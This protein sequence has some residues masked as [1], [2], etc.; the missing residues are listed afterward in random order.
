MADDQTALDDAELESA[1]AR[2]DPR[3]AHHDHVQSLIDPLERQGG[4][5]ALV[6]GTLRAVVG[7]MFHWTPPEA[8]EAKPAMTPEEALADA[9]ATGAAER[10]AANQTGGEPPE[11]ET[12]AADP[13]EA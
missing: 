6:A 5:A 12:Q 7:G 2:T 4:L 10:E 1:A 8:G 9:K 13:L 3:A 11:A